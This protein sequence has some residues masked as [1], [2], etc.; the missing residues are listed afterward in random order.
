MA[1]LVFEIKE[2]YSV[3]ILFSYWILIMRLDK[4]HY[5]GIYVNAFGSIITRSIPLF[6]IV[7][8][9]LIGF[10][11]S[12]RNR[13]NLDFYSNDANNTNQTAKYRM[14][15]FDGSFSNSIFKSLEFLVGGLNIGEMGVT[16][17]NRISFINYVIYGCF[18]FVMTILFVNIFT[19]ISIDEIQSLI[20]HSE[21]QIQS[22]KIDYV[23]KLESLKNRHTMIKHFLSLS[24]W[25]YIGILFVFKIIKTIIKKIDLKNYFLEC[26][27][28]YNNNKIQNQINDDELD[29]REK[30]QINELKKIIQS[31]FE[32]IDRKIKKVE[33]NIQTVM[34][35]KLMFKIK[36]VDRKLEEILDLVKKK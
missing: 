8:I 23:F 35:E 22:R 34:D 31:K 2:F 13:T 12:F 32:S 21:A 30:N 36:E 3:T 19:G 5:I 28:K 10:V 26:Y 6:V 25:I 27:K 15:H 20:K 18:I 11:L 7:L 16:E 4:F 29:K 33:D 17:V 24:N 14:E 1:L 9:N